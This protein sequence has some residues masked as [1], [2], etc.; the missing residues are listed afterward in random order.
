MSKHTYVS[1][2]YPLCC[3]QLL[4]E[5]VPKYLRFVCKGI[6]TCSRNWDALDQPDD[7]PEEGEFI[8][9]AVLRD[10]GSLHID[11]RVNGRRVGEWHATASYEPILPQPDQSLLRDNDKWRD[12]CMERESDG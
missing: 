8:I 9:A 1:L 2:N 6:A 5:R 4:V 3:K 12:W 7:T 11:K 10:R